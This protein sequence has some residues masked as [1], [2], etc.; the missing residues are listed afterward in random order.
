MNK[1]KIIIGDLSM[2]LRMMITKFERGKLN[3]DYIKKVKDYLQRKDLQGNIIRGM[4]VP[5]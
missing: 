4:D 5:S 1:D 3:D 2:M